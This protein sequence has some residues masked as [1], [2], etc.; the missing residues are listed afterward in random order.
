MA[1]FSRADFKTQSTVN[2][3]HKYFTI[4]E[5][6]R[7][8]PLVRRIAE[9]MQ[10]AELQRRDLVD[11]SHTLEGN[12]ME[13]RAL[14]RQFDQLT[15][16]LFDLMEELNQIGVDLKDP[17]RGLLDFPA[18]LDDRD[19]LLCWELGEDSINHWHETHTGYASRRS[20]SE[21]QRC[22]AKRLIK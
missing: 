4:A 16:R 2:R 12:S 10:N 15:H 21:M 3:E 6:N 18:Q 13:L 20:V 8:L 1:V 5:A 11:L 7:A 17:T 22:P 19:I 14:E 9:D